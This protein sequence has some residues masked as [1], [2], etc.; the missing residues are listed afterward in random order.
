MKQAQ[1]NLLSNASKYTPR[2]GKIWYEIEKDGSE[3]VI[4]VRDSGE[5]I[6]DDLLESIFELFV[7]SENTLARS[8]GG[9]RCVS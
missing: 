8:S 4:T 5:G 2:A 6:P 7:Q 9:N 3:A 1:V